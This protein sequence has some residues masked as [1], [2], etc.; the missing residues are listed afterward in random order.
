MR[1]TASSLKKGVE[2]DFGN[3]GSLANRFRISLRWNG[4]KGVYEVY[5]FFYRTRKED[6]VFS[7]PR[8]DEAVGR[9]CQIANYYAKEVFG[10]PIYRDVA[11]EDT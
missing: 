3:W 7:S 11:V 10:E 9:A 8:L 5:K 1:I 4:K 6:V 2:V